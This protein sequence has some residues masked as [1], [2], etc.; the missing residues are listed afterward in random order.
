[1]DNNFTLLLRTKSVS[2]FI[3]LKVD[4]TFIKVSE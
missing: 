2:D 4:V 3:T 1:M